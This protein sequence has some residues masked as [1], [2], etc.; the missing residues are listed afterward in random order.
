MRDNGGVCRTE[1]PH[2]RDSVLLKDLRR[3]ATPAAL[4]GVLVI[5][6]VLALYLTTL[7]NGLRLDELTGGDL[8]THQYSQVQARPS[9]AP[10]YP[11]YTMGGWL[12]FR[13]GG[14][15]LP[16]LFNPVEILSLYSTLWALAALVTLYVLIREVTD[17][18]W[19]I[20]ALGTLFYSFT[21]F[22]WY[23]SCSTEQYTSA[24]FQTLLMVLWAFRWER[25][26]QHKYLYLLAFM[27]G[28]CLAN[29][30]TVLFILPPLLV[31]IL[32]GEPRIFTRVK[33]VAGCLIL[34]LL[35]LVSYVYVYVRG[36]QHPE[37]WGIGQWS[38]P[39]QW[40][41]S[42]IATQQGRDELTWFLGPLTAEF[43]G[44]IIWDMSAIGLILALVGWWLLG[45]RRG[46]FLFGALAIYLI[47]S[48]IDRFGNWY[49]VFMPVYPLFAMGM[50]VT[51]DRIWR[52][53]GTRHHHS[54]WRATVVVGLG[55]L[56]ISRLTFPDPRAFQHDRPDDDGLHP[57]WVLLADQPSQ[58]ATIIGN[59][60]QFVSLEYLTE[61]WGARSDVNA[62]RLSEAQ[63][64]I[65]DQVPS[66]YVTSQVAPLVLPELEPSVHPSGHGAELV[67]LRF[68]SVLELPD[69]AQPLSATL[70][71]S[72]QLAG[73]QFEEEKIGLNTRESTSEP[74]RIFHLT[75]FWRALENMYT[76]WS[77]SVR[78]TSAGRLLPT[79]AGI[80]QM[81]VPHPVLG[82]YPMSKWSPGEIVRD[83]Y[84][85]PLR[86]D[87]SYDGAQVVVYHPT[88]DGFENLGEVNI[89]FPK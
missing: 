54:A 66:L 42:F 15:L 47:F 37:W 44:L 4:A 56:V 23:Y 74:A 82:L 52:W 69:S 1:L 64:L 31:L 87:Q 6:I 73:Y 50:A 88:G 79:E 27:T 85:I 33:L 32:T 16:S 45:R 83:D 13:V 53:A 14:L 43:P 38:T 21:Y 55:L 57:G 84:V 76:D 75:L 58:G 18:N 8:V 48:Y 11:L 72:L 24:I 36:A 12:W 17:D 71:D 41:V 40:F 60:G 25:T 81:D 89:A 9:N 34:V 20:A 62:A 5:G 51:A 77:V 22:F 49:Q 86:P 26:R 59:A 35:P 80:V 70:G 3:S 28:L 7:D 68:E 61:I 46:G 29:L 67:E 2:K 78:P 10:G 65:E 39:W 30:V 63:S 19:P